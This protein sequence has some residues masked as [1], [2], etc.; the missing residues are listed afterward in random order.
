MK[1]AVFAFTRKGC[2]L[3]LRVRRAL[4]PSECRMVTMEKFGLPDFEAYT[5]PLSTCMESYFFWADAIVFVG[6]TGMAVRAIAPWIRDKKRDPA[7]IAVDEGGNFAVSMLSG[8][9]GGANRMTTLLAEEIGA[10][11]VITTATDVEGRF[12]P[13][14]WAAQAGFTVSS[15]PACK[16]VSA[17]ILEEDIPMVCEKTVQKFPAGVISGSSGKLG[18]F[19]GVHDAYPFDTTLRLTPKALRLGIGCRRGTAQEKIRTAVEAVLH[20]HNLASDAL[21]GIYS[22]DLKANEQG[23]LDYA[24]S[25]GVPCVF[26]T[27]RELMQ[28]P[29]DYPASEFVKSVT[30]VDNVCQRAAMLGAKTLLVSKTALDGVTVAIA[31]NDWEAV[32]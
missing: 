21:C 32:F 25:L 2:K 4:S 3:A 8:H 26:Y 1:L 30:G 5:P 27:S 16:A 6:S 29:G 7:V 15:W 18:I 9:L 23:L 28:A 13:D 24:K 14:A 31:E 12:S 17:A 22:I 10:T 19:V 20:N 11:A